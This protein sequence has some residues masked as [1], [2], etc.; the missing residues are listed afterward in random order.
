MK[1]QQIDVI[2]VGGGHAGIEAAL[3]SARLG[4]SVLLVSIDINGIGV[5]PCNPSIGGPAKGQIV[6]E[7]DVVH[8]YKSYV[9]GKI[10]SS[11]SEVKRGDF[12]S[13]YVPVIVQM[14]VAVPKGDLDGKIIEK[15]AQSKHLSTTRD[16]VFINRGSID[17]VIEGQTFYVISQRDEFID[18]EDNKDIPPSVVG[19]ILV[20]RV[21]DDHSVAVITDASRLLEIGDQVSM[22]VQ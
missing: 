6:G 12:V 1:Q 20:V 3:A 9:V 17:G 16:T 7:I 15:L 5:M 21:E 18:K 13:P 4:C 14:E 10:R 22:F 11:Y 2:V 19:R 8:H